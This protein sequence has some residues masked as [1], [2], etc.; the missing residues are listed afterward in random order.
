MATT[1]TDL[2]NVDRAF[3][4]AWIV[5]INGVEV[6]CVSVGVSYGVW[7]IP[8]AEIAVVPDP[9]LHRLGAEDR[10]SVQV[11]YCDYWMDPANPSFRLLFDGEIVGW[12]YV[13]SGRNRLLSF[14]AVDYIQIWTQLFF[15]FMSS[16]DDLATGASGDSIGVNVNGVQGVG[17]A[18]IYPYS[19]FA[20]GIVPASTGTESETDG[21][22][23]SNPL[24]TRPLDFVYNV[25][26]ALIDVRLPNRS[27]PAANF[28]APWTR[29]TNFHKRFVALPM[30]ESS[31]RSGVFPILRAV[32]ANYAISAVAQQVTSIGNS[33]S[34]MDMFRQVL[35]VLMMEIAMVP[36]ATAVKSNFTT[37]EIDGPLPETTTPLS[38]TFLTNY[39]VKPQCLFGLPPSCNVFFPSQVVRF[40]YNEN[41]IT[42]PTRMYFSEEALLSYLRVD[43]NA[44]PGL[45]TMIRD[46]VSVAHP[47][48]VNIAARSAVEHRGENSRNLLVYP[49][50]FFKGPVVDRRPLPTWFSFLQQA[51]GQ[52]NGDNPEATPADPDVASDITPGDTER[53]VFRLYAKYEYFR[54]KY[55][56]RT[57]GVELVFNPYPVPGFPC[58]VFDR[59]STQVD[60]MGYISRV[61]HQLTSNSWS[62]SVSF[63]HGRTIQEMFQLMDQQFRF[64]NTV[65]QETQG[66]T[67]QRVLSQ[68]VNDEASGNPEGTR[69]ANPVGVIAT[70]PPEPL[71]EIRDVTQNFDRAERFY[72]ALFHKVA[73]PTSEDLSTSQTEAALDRAPPAESPTD[74]DALDPTPAGVEV[75]AAVLPVTQGQPSIPGTVDLPVTKK[76]SFY[77]P[78]IIQVTDPNG[79]EPED[80][81]LSGID[82]T[83]RNTALDAI[84]HLRAN[85]ATPEDITLLAAIS[86]L[87]ADR[88]SGVDPT[89]RGPLANQLELIIRTLP[90]TS[91]LRG[92]V[93]I[94]P[95]P[96]AAGLFE[97]YEQAMRYVARPICT[98]D[99]YINFLGEQ[100]LREGAVDPGQALASNDVR[101]FPAVFYRQIRV[102]RPGPPPVV[103]TTDITN[104]QGLTSADGVITA[105]GPTEDAE[106][107]PDSA[108]PQAIQGL[109]ADFPETR[110]DWTTLLLRYRDNV[111]ASLVPRT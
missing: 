68:S 102:Y 38:P 92:D 6:P 43:A 23:A 34:I 105:V 41:Y 49:E 54:E 89:A 103:P 45:A 94:T 86:N 1:D 75:P 99:E 82:S 14:T 13:N 71:A 93:Y 19:L 74:L 35:N 18:P 55:G 67:V 44:G 108:T 29:R 81:Q 24:I 48:E 17:Y 5:Y 76:A 4:I 27:V 46:A 111:L 56:N 78:D 52:G 40:T 87:P 73:A 42:Q 32:Q 33:A 8:E 10:I 84:A 79:G 96:E 22:T 15:F 69:Q 11:F 7:A 37:L 20:E 47:E 16:T 101:A 66:F 83:A 62:S 80:I 110:Y 109:P 3:Q 95:K 106:E 28:F 61:S 30:L 65:A 63:T 31:D 50:E 53:D 90:I 25:V 36:T 51:Q 2:V 12:G 39:F 100:G 77:Y 97:S 21:G 58:C 9:S 104:T 91:N 85:T 57:G 72:G 26:R 88:I 98:L 60:V 64:E 107:S 70:G 59:R